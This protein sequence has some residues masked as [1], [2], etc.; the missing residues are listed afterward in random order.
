MIET[1]ELKYPTDDWTKTIKAGILPIPDTTSSTYNINIGIKGN[2]ALKIQ[3]PNGVKTLMLNGDWSQY[4]G[5]LTIP[6]NITKICFS[7]QEI[8]FNIVAN[9]N[10]EF[11]I[12]QPTT[13]TQQSTTAQTLPGLFGTLVSTA[14]QSTNTNSNLTA[15]TL[16][17]SGNLSEC[18]GTISFDKSVSKI[19]LSTDNP[20][21]AIGG[22]SDLV[23]GVSDLTSNAVTL[24]SS[25]LNR[26]GTVTL[27]ESVKTVTLK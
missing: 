19:I 7:N 25:I 26:K 11:G 6:S 8:P 12:T 5:T 23:I 22:D 17:F 13:K 18:T 15:G 1:E 3:A 4:T 9:H 20:T 10:L 2:E 24:K 14:Q 21:F 27:D 16:K